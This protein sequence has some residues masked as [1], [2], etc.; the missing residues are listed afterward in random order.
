MERKEPKPR[1]DV[2]IIGSGIGGL[3]AGALL[4]KAGLTVCVLEKEPHPGG[5]LAGFRR[6]DFRF[7]TAIHWL[8]QYTKEGMVCRLF[9]ALGNDY[10]RAISQQRIRRF[11]GDDY[12]YLLTNRPDDLK[13]QWKKEFPE[14]ADGIDRFFRAAKKVGEAFKNFGHIFRAE[15]TMNFA[16]KLRKKKNL[17]LFALRFIPHLRYAGEKG[18]KKG[19]SKYFKSKRLHEVF[20]ADTELLSCIVPIGWAYYNDFQSP[21]HGGGQVIA[22]W[23]EH[24]IQY[25][26][27]ETHYRYEVRQILT[28]GNTACGVLCTHSGKEYTIESKY[29][30]AASDAPT[31]YSKLLPAAL[32]PAKLKKNLEKA[33]LYSSSVTISI[34]LDCP[35]ETLGFNEELIH[36]S[37]AAVPRSEQAAGD[38]LRT[39]MCILAPSFRDK[40]LAPDGQG[41]LLLFMPADMKFEQQWRTEKDEQGNFIRGK[42]YK[43]LKDVIARQLIQRVEEKVAPGLQKHILFY[44]VATPITH[45]RYTGNTGGSMMA[46]KPNRLNM[47]NKVAT[48]RTPVKNLLVGGHWAELGGGVPIAVKAG[49]NSAMLILKKEN[50]AAYKAFSAYIDG[51]SDLSVL[52]QSSA[53]KP[54]SNNWQQ[55]PTPAQMKELRKTASTTVNNIDEGNEES[56]E[57]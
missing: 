12:E 10:P 52:Q 42:A 30:I 15:E 55:K 35:V 8:N 44:E 18:I 3:T 31:L 20:S 39:E 38:P 34:A 11:K 16:E 9:D 24:V 4:S 51:R 57:M 46:T 21:P 28:K 32:V 49:A 47:M 13:E 36:V 25:F 33:E 23:L 29:V 56:M 50:Q 45:W 1:Y 2:V 6:K 19:L 37:S 41:T 54:Y 40:S 17:I 14:D 7:D 53:F 43:E 48:Y 5:Y 27:Q 26:S 22:E